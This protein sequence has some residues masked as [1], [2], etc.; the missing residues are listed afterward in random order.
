MTGL[1]NV[2]F[3]DPSLTASKRHL[4]ALCEGILKRNLGIKWRCYSRADVP[5]EIFELMKSMSRGT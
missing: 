5:S 4:V 2:T 3:D 1:S